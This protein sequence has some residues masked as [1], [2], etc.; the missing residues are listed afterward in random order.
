MDATASTPRRADTPHTI[1]RV[2]RKHSGDRPLV[3][4]NRD[5]GRTNTA[6]SSIHNRRGNAGLEIATARRGTLLLCFDQAKK[7]RAE[8]GDGTNNGY[9]HCRV[10]FRIQSATPDPPPSPPS[11]LPTFSAFNPINATIIGQVK[12]FH[13]CV[14]K[15]LILDW[16]GRHLERA[17]R[18]WKKGI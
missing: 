17:G 13:Y 18:P 8:T 7:T 4:S 3:Q 15:Q 10:T 12:D 6:P 9:H 5:N 2:R 1:G 16:P 14:T 11:K